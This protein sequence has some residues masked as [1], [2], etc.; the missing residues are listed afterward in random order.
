MQV[1]LN[2][3]LTSV[4]QADDGNG[5]DEY[6]V[7]ASASSEVRASAS[8]VEDAFE[9]AVRYAR[10]RLRDYHQAPFPVALNTIQITVLF[11]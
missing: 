6:E 1:S 2:V 3:E 5:G 8:S 9:Q 7:R 11:I 4:V 10:E